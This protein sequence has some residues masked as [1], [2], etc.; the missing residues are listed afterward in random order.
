M[1]HLLWKITISLAED[2]PPL[3][4]TGFNWQSSR[5]FVFNRFASY[6]HKS[7]AK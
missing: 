6:L 5:F 1:V 3:G 2:S 4:Q 7:F